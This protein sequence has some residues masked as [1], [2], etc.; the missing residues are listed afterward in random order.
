MVRQKSRETGTTDNVQFSFQLRD[1][2]GPARTYAIVRDQHFFFH[3]ETP[4]RFR[5][6]GRCETWA[7]ARQN[8]F[9]R[10]YN[11]LDLRYKRYMAWI[12]LQRKS[13]SDMYCV[14]KFCSIR[15]DLHPQENPSGQIGYEGDIKIKRSTLYCP[16]RR[17]YRCCFL[18]PRGSLFLTHKDRVRTLK[19]ERH[20]SGLLSQHKGSTNK[21]EQEEREK[22]TIIAPM[23]KVKTFITVSNIFLL[24]LKYN[25]RFM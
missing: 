22:F 5:V 13:N 2:T 6:R 16:R 24:L 8:R 17:S 3:H 4:K 19:R 25:P 7:E 21:R 9:L 10:T 23:P 12:K 15:P 11:F 1:S 14:L 18:N 20:V